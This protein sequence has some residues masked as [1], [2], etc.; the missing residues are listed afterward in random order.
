MLSSFSIMTDQIPQVRAPPDRPGHCEV[1]EC[2]QDT[3][4]VHHD[5]DQIADQKIHGIVALASGSVR[6]EQVTVSLD[7][8]A[9]QPLGR[10]HFLAVVQK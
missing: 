8:S 10:T 9:C 7:E 2:H 1:C 3:F 5:S 6:F 4:A